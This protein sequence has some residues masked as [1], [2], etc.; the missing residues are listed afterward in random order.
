MNLLESLEK[1]YPRRARTTHRALS[2]LMEEKRMDCSP[3]RLTQRD[4]MIIT[5][6][7]TFLSE[8]EPPLKVLKRFMDRHVGDLVS[9]V[10]ILPMFPYSSD[11]GFSVIDYSAI[12]PELGS[13]EDIE[14]LSKSYDLM[15][16]AVI[17][18]ISKESAWFEAYRRGD[19]EFEDFFIEYD[20]SEDY[21][22]VVRPRSSPLFHA[23][24]TADGEKR[25]WT[26]FSEDQLDL[27][28]KNPEVLCKVMEVLIDYARRGARFIRLD[29]V[30]FLWKE[31]GSAS[32]HHDH[33]HRIIRIM[34]HVLS[35]TVPGTK[36]ITETNVPH[37]ENISYFG[38]GGEEADLVY[39]FPLPPL[40]LHGILTGDAAILTR[41]AASLEKTPPP[42]GCTYFNF[43][44]SHDGIG[45]RPTESFLDDEAR[46]IMVRHTQDQGGMVSYKTN[47]DESES[48]YELNISYFDALH[49]EGDSQARHIRKFLTAHGILLAFKGVPGIYIHSLLGSEGD[50]EGARV[51]GIPRRINRAKIDEHELEKA[52]GEP[53]TMRSRIFTSMTSMLHLRRETD[54][55]HPEAPQTVIRHDDRVLA[56]K[57][58]GVTSEVLVLANLSEDKVTID[59]GFK[60]VD[61]ISR[62]KHG[63]QVSMTPY[64]IIWLTPEG[65]A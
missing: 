34:K 48:V 50:Y 28:Y 62:E 33:T 63:A 31:S 11:D 59:A 38:E 2:T 45:M 56:F 25:L 54:A 64:Q 5:Y 57:R 58:D 14:N 10:H 65:M 53:E 46:G 40:V 43:L 44:A 17:N 47:L 15:L 19:P 9:A 41:W 36:L 8:E 61:M 4:M 24:E 23:Y 16:D 12:D 18:H 21:S 6:G 27:N 29:A 26:T 13:W 42:A 39:Q 7:N 32:I 1:L 30:G 35:E 49:Q 55:F 52:L 20:P 37:E 3:K 51:S 60:G 22:E